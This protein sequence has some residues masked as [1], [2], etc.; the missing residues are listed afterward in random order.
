LTRERQIKFIIERVSIWRK[1]YTGVSIQ[2][3]AGPQSFR[4]SLLDAARLVGISKKSLD[5]YLLQIRF[6]K[7]LGFDFLTN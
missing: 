6:G 2:T 4:Y 7:I 1:L 3:K 5:D